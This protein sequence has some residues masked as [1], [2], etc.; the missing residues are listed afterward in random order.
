MGRWGIPAVIE[1]VDGRAPSER[2]E[3]PSC[4]WLA[5][6]LVAG[7]VCAVAISVGAQDGTRPLWTF[8]SEQDIASYGLIHS[9]DLFVSTK[10]QS[11]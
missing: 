4:W 10:T 8:T 7:A 2:A 6:L 9:G 3:R 5:H 1:D 11:T